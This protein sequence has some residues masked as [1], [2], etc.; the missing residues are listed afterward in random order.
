MQAFMFR[1]IRL[2]QIC[3]MEIILG[4]LALIVSWLYSQGYIQLMHMNDS[5]TLTNVERQRPPGGR[6]HHG[7]TSGSRGRPRR[8]VTNWPVTGKRRISSTIGVNFIVINIHLKY[9]N[10]QSIDPWSKWSQLSL[11][12]LGSGDREIKLAHSLVSILT[13]RITG[14]APLF[15][16]ISLSYRTLVI[17][18]N[19][20]A[21]WYQ[22]CWYKL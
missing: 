1:I 11:F 10:G 16:E 15:M 14:I 19:I 20:S 18:R 22:Y 7:E 2:T 13:M 8:T 17:W 3:Q 4:Y 12:V 6:D 9:H 5:L 21:K